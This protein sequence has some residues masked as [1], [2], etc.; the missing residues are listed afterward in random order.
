MDLLNRI[1]TTIESYGYWGIFVGI[2]V[3]V[4][5]TPI[6]SEVIMGYAGYLVYKGQMNLFLAALSGATANIIGSLVIYSL[7]LV[8]GTQVIPKVGKYIGVG[9]KEYQKALNVF[10][11]HGGLSVLL[12]QVIPGLRSVIALPAGI[13]KMNIVK[14]I[15]SVFIGSMVWCS[16]LVYVSY[17][18]GENWEKFTSFISNLEHMILIVCALLAFS[19]IFI[20][21]KKRR[22]SV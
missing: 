7:G 8:F 14:F 13:A 12:S 9:E 1:I 10:N 17:K 3:E 5:I 15:V 21:I 4:I 6:P 18:L 20:F 2:V 22:K 19:V 11:K 16:F